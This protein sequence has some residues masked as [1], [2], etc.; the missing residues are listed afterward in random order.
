MRA[1]VQRVAYDL[2]PKSFVVTFPKPRRLVGELPALELLRR[3]WLVA[4]QFCLRLTW[5]SNGPPLRRQRQ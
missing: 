3:C 2:D 5:S 4:A 1:I